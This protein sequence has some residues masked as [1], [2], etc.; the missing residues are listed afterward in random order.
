M[1]DTLHSLEGDTSV[2]GRH[3]ACLQQSH[4]VSQATRCLCVE[5]R[6][7]LAGETLLRRRRQMP[8]AG[9]PLSV[10][11][12]TPGVRRRSLQVAGETLLV[13]QRHTAC[14]EFVGRLRT[15]LARQRHKACS[16]ETHC[17]RRRHP[18][19]WELQCLFARNTLPSQET[20]V[21]WETQSLRR[22]SAE[23]QETQGRRSSRRRR[24]CLTPCICSKETRVCVGDTV[25]GRR[26]VMLT[27]RR[28][29]A[30]L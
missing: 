22:H 13:C 27:R 10:A 25:R 15:L 12:D 29:A 19:L 8:V 21:R 17:I 6:G 11:G 3:S 4:V 26:R 24:T 18:W 14:D 1:L 5:A 7:Y 28:H 2:C 16:Q 9:G 30:C 23:P 20:R